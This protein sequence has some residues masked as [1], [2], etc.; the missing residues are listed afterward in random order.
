M[1]T[2]KTCKHWQTE[3]D[4]LFSV[5][6]GWYPCGNERFGQMIAK[7]RDD[8]GFLYTSPDFACVYHEEIP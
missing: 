5:E 2:C 7:S 8:I 6:E 3:V 1:N 4:T